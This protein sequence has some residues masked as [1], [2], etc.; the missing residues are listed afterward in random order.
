MRRGGASKKRDFGKRA[1]FQVKD[2]V[3]ELRPRTNHLGKIG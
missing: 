2:E 3:V 1:S